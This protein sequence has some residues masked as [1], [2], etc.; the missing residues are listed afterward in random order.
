MRMKLEQASKVKMWTP[1]RL[2]NGEGC[3]DREETLRGIA[4][5]DN[6]RAP[7]PV[8][9][10]SEHGMWGRRSG[11]VGEARDWLE[12]RV[13]ERRQKGRRPVWESERAIRPMRPGNAGGG[14]GPCFWCVL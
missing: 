9:R 2:R 5:L 4:Q 13:S 6:Q 10:G 14:K 11:S 3:T 1:T 8:H 7:D 12:G